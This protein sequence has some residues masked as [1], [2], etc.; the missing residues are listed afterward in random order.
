MTLGAIFKIDAK[1]FNTIHASEN[2]YKSLVTTLSVSYFHSYSFVLD[3]TI[4]TA[5][6]ITFHDRADNGRDETFTLRVRKV[7]KFSDEKI[8]EVKQ[9]IIDNGGTILRQKIKRILQEKMSRVQANHLLDACDLKSRGVR[10]ENT[11]YL[12][13]EYYI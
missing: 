8:Q 11:D 6:Q 3:H 13:D 10:S 5:N 4:K 9:I 2:E 12:V 7:T 1:D